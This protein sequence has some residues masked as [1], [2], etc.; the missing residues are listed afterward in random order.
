MP[1]VKGTAVLT[2]TDTTVN[3]RG[4]DPDARVTM[5]VNY[6]DEHGDPSFSINAY[7]TTDPKGEFTWTVPFGKTYVEEIK[8]LMGHPTDVDH[9]ECDGETSTGQPVNVES[10]SD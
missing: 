2:D 6:I 3:F 10:K 7:A 1:K 4:L 8:A 9:V 5:N